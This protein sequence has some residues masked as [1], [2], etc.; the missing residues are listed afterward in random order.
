M[1]K[2]LKLTLL[3]A[4]SL[5]IGVLIYLMF[6]KKDSKLYVLNRSRGSNLDP[7]QQGE[8]QSGQV[9]SANEE[10]S[11]QPSGNSGG[12]FFNGST[13]GN[14]FTSKSEVKAFQDYVI[15]VKKDSDILGS[16]GADGLWG[17]NTANA[18]EKYGS[19]Y[20]AFKDPLK[21]VKS[22]L[23]N[24]GL[25][26]TITSDGAVRVVYSRNTYKYVARYYNNRRVVFYINGQSKFLSKGNYSSGGKVIVI[27]EGRRNGS[28]F[29]N[30]SVLK[31]MQSATKPTTS[32]TG[33]TTNA[34]GKKVFPKD[35][36]IN[37]RSTPEVNNGWI[38]NKM[39]IINS[40]N[41]IGKVVNFKLGSESTPKVWYNVELLTP[42]KDSA[43]P[44]AIKGW[45]RSDVV[46]F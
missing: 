15:N 8:A 11:P 41:V 5:A 30:S 34:V 23:K 17:S 31:N 20:D 29:N 12:G 4:G 28:S 32:A 27:T 42:L 45:V 44:N 9:G 36:Y 16:Y 19:E 39:G 24:L 10:P 38:N 43:Q 33:S 13:I 26:Y 18:Y 7:L 6:I 35:D 2:G 40:P 14:P 21:A 37:V 1:K 22:S 3:I 46:K 25:N